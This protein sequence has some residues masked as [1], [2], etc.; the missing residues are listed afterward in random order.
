MLFLDY[1]WTLLEFD[2]LKNDEDADKYILNSENEL[3]EFVKKY[4]QSN[5]K[6]NTSTNDNLE[7]DII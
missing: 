3:N 5:L 1:L 4:G 6:T 7:T 2:L